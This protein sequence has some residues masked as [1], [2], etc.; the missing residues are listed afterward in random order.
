MTTKILEGSFSTKMEAQ[1]GMLWRKNGVVFVATKRTSTNRGCEDCAFR[2]AIV[3]NTPFYRCC[4]ESPW[5]LTT[6]MKWLPFEGFDIVNLQSLID[7]SGG[8]N[9]R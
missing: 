9:G 2:L 6:R 5:C 7:L 1:E 8:N 4:G 3:R